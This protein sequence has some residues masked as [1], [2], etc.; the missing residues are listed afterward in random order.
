MHPAA[1]QGVCGGASN[2]DLIGHWSKRCLVVAED[3]GTSRSI[4]RTFDIRGPSCV[5]RQQPTFWAEE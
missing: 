4:E 2:G 5:L 1:E 3:N